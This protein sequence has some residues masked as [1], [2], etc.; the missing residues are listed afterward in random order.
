MH[1][2]NPSFIKPILL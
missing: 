2:L 1:A